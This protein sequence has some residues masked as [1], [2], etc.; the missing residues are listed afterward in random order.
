MAAK[1][2]D[3]KKSKNLH[4]SMRVLAILR[5][6]FSR[7]GPIFPSLL[8]R[9][10][11]DLWFKTPRIDLIPEREIAWFNETKPSI[12]AVEI[13]SDIIE[14][15]PL[16]VMTYYWENSPH[17]QGPLVMLMHG[18][19]GRASQMAGFAAPL[20]KAGFR[21]LAFD[22]HAHAL[23]PGKT[24]T[25]FKQSAVQVALAEKFGPVYAVVAH[26][27]GGM[28]TPYSLNHGFETQKVVCI[29]APSDFNVLIA[30]YA[31]AVHL[32]EKIQQYIYNRFKKIYG[33]DFVEQISGMVTA[34]SLGH[35]PA[36]IIHDEDDEDVPLTESKKLHQAW[37]NSRFKQTSGM[38]HREILYNPQVIEMV[39]NFLKA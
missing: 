19:T 10:A 24:T 1:P 8:G 12:E 31:A 39:V 35:I 9:F 16:P 14:I 34:K 3:K 27:F 23:T 26:S 4:K 38:D 30:R 28:V 36:L 17:D 7:L 29:S 20:L 11:Y 25:I 22:N 21:V 18:W 33:E 6:I 2:I 13:S 5:F 32:P 37:P 15:K